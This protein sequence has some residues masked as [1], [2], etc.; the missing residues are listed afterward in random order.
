MYSLSPIALTIAAAA[1]IAN[2]IPQTFPGDLWLRATANPSATAETR[3]ANVFKEAENS[4]VLVSEIA[5]HM[6]RP[7]QAAAQ[8]TGFP[9]GDF[10]IAN[11]R[12]HEKTI[13]FNGIP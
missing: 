3:M 13:A 12:A 7:I 2:A 6:T 9:A 4:R 1:T 10:Q 11:K 5:A 8:R